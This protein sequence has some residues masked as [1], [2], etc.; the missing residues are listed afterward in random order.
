AGCGGGGSSSGGASDQMIIVQGI[1][2]TD[3]EELP[4]SPDATLNQNVVVT[5]SG[6]PRF[7]T[8]LDPADQVSG[9]RANVRIRDHRGQRVSGVAFLGGRDPQGRTVHERQPNVN[10][11]LANLL[12]HDGKDI[13]RFVADADGDLNTIETFKID[14]T[15]T[16]PAE[17]I[18]VEVTTGVTN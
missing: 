8:V 1:S 5:F 14:P 6:A 11:A 2:P 9:L 16:P 7:E 17:Q 12:D 18:S 4:T 13:L 15:L 3:G 10:A